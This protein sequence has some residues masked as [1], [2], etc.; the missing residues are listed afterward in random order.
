MKRKQSIKTRAI[1]AVMDADRP[2][3]VEALGVKTGNEV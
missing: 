3:T 1:Q 2:L